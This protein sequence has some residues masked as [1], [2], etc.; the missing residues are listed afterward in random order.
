MTD[1]ISDAAVRRVVGLRKMRGLTRDQLAARCAGAG[2]PELTGPALANIETGRR[3]PEGQRRRDVT[4]DELAVLATALDVLPSELVPELRPDTDGPPPA[5]PL[6]AELRVVTANLAAFIEARA[7]EIAD[8]RILEA[9][10]RAAFIVADLTGRHAVERQRW[11]A[12]EAELRRQLDAQL[13]QV[14]WHRK[15]MTEAGLDLMTGKP[16]VAP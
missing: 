11:A 16:K 2:R 15:A 14:S 1:S 8:P 4:V 10:Q 12:L 13:R 7:A 3:G 9:E 6:A 5:E